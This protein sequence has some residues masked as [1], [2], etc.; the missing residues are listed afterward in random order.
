MEINEDF[1]L[2]KD[3][4]R[5]L[6]FGDEDVPN[7]E[8][9]EKNV[10]LKQINEKELRKEITNYWI[11]YLGNS[12]D[13]QNLKELFIESYSF[14]KKQDND[15]KN[16]VKKSEL[17][18][19]LEE[20]FEKS[21]EVGFKIG[22]ISREQIKEIL[23]Y[24]CPKISKNFK[25]WVGNYVNLLVFSNKYLHVTLHLKLD[26]FQDESFIITSIFSFWFE[27]PN[28]ISNLDINYINNSYGNLVAMNDFLKK[29][30]SLGYRQVYLFDK[31]RFDNDYYSNQ[32]ILNDWVNKIPLFFINKSKQI[33]NANPLR[34]FDEIA[35]DL[36]N[37]S[38]IFIKI[39]KNMEINPTQWFDN[40]NQELKLFYNKGKELFLNISNII[41]PISSTGEPEEHEII[42]KEDKDRQKI[43]RIFFLFQKAMEEDINNPDILPKDKGFRTF[44]Q[45]F[46]HYLDKR[47]RDKKYDY[48]KPLSQGAFYALIKK[49]KHE[50]ESVLEKNHDKGQGG[51]D[52]Y[53]IIKFEREEI[54]KTKFKEKPV[55]D[56]KA[57]ELKLLPVRIHEGFF[58]YNNQ[59]YEEAVKIFQQIIDSSYSLLKNDEYYYPGLLYHIGKC[60]IKGGNFHEAIKIFKKIYDQDKNKVDVGFNLLISFFNVGDY[61]KA[62]SLA[63]GLYSFLKE[64]LSPYRSLDNENILFRED[65]HFLGVKPETL[66]PNVLN[67]EVFNKYLIML[68]RDV[69]IQE[70]TE[71]L[72]R[73]HK[74]WEE[75]QRKYEKAQDQSYYLSINIYTF[76]KLKFL[77]LSTLHYILEIN[78]RM[79]INSLVFNE[80]EE[81]FNNQLSKIISF[82]KEEITEESIRYQRINDFL[83]FTNKLAELIIKDKLE[84]FNEKYLNLFPEFDGKAVGPTLFIPKEVKNI[85]NYL[86]YI[87]I[88]LPDNNFEWAREQ[89][90]KEV[91][92]P[93]LIA[94][95]MVLEV[96]SFINYDLEKAYQKSETDF[97]SIEELDGEEI[98]QLFP[99]WKHSIFLYGWGREV[100]YI[101]DNLEGFIEFCENNDLTLYSEKLKNLKKQLDI[102]VKQIIDKKSEGRKG[103]IK[104]LLKNRYESFE[105]E[106][107]EITVDLR[108]KPDHFKYEDFFHDKIF[109][110]IFN[111]RHQHIGEKKITYLLFDPIVVKEVYQDLL[112]KIEPP[113]EVH[114]NLENNEIIYNEYYSA[115]PIHIRSDFSLFL[116]RF[117]YDFFDMFELKTDKYYLKYIPEIKQ[118][119]RKYFQTKFIDEFKSPYFDFNIKD[120]PDVMYYSISI[121][122]KGVK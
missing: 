80:D 104:K 77:L 65:Y 92:R 73:S 22:E 100:N 57:K 40:L 33:L 23:N 20:N 118:D 8:F 79:L 18:T 26:S 89:I 67:R 66:H 86:F 7:E 120:H 94:E 39:E 108:E 49:Y 110:E 60:Y 36:H 48:L 56:E 87:N 102:K 97:K 81:K 96:I 11:Q 70:F 55:L 111:L 35:S 78:R 3:L 59:D 54:T 32:E 76:S 68:N 19:F 119:V 99:K 93:E 27:H 103:V 64:R 116:D 115:M 84:E 10:I 75:Y 52:L 28:E 50:L 21:L 98:N 5:E 14:W 42:E 2:L 121:K 122:K 62:I 13:F 106:R 61:Q 44:H 43:E 17:I 16:T 1:K 53:R 74:D 6:Y 91:R 107:Y 63:K 83:L 88:A 95:S 46:T 82:L 31:S 37:L 34:L 38:E 25:G 30:E 15:F 72:P 101:R 24:R 117:L 45:L 85:G 9:S 90:K 4:L 12:V 114:V 71:L 41:E 109:R 47:I 29:L 105:I 51:G 112:D 69:Q 113:N 58:Y